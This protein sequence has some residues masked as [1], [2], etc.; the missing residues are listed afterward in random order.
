MTTTLDISTTLTQID[1]GV[2]GGVYAIN[3][4][5]HSH[6]RQKGTSWTCPYCKTGWGFQG[7][8]TE[9]KLKRDLA[10]AEE[11][12]RNAQRERDQAETRASRAKTELKRTQTRI[13]N[14]VCPCCNRSFVKLATH[15][16]RMHP[17]YSK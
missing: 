10:A 6:A 14:G 3:E 12:A 4:R 13:H 15:M 1:C 11:R 8:G 16:T 7:I 17:E 2:C 5:Y 9:E